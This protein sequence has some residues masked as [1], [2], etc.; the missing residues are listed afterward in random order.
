[1]ARLAV[2][3]PAVSRRSATLIVSG[4]LLA[5][6][7]LVAALLPVPYVVFRPGPLTDVLGDGDDG[8]IIQVDGAEAYATTGS[9]DLTTV[10]VTPAG[11][12]MD[13]L[14]AMRAWV[15]PDRA[16]VPRDIVYPGNPTTEE[17]REVNS[18]VFSSSQELASVA[19][20]RYLGYDVPVAADQV[21][22]RDVLDGA[23]AEGVLEPGDEIL[24][25]D[26][27]PVTSPGDVVDAVSVR[28]PGETVPMQVIRDGEP[29]D[30][31]VPTSESEVDPG[32]AA[33]GVVVGQAWDLPVEVTID[34]PGQ[35]GGSSA[36][37]VFTLG[38]VDTLTPDGLLGG[39]AVAGTG[40][41]SPDGTVGAI[42]GVQQ[43]IA[44]ARDDGAVVFLVPTA[45]CTSALGA[46][47][48][49]MLVIPVDSLDDAVEVLA[50]VNEDDRDALPS[51][52]AVA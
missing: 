51:C 42:S 45:N 15:D 38:I 44:A 10:G 30:L 20:L 47:A 1:M 2:R 26:G 24:V 33:I 22:V 17:A 11:A 14:T 40:E 12:K 21:V 16:V 39:S 19:A 46:D 13:L 52:A 36:G 48:G 49:D 34:V 50:A 35:I 18:A 29:L 43:K 4:V 27:E 32:S 3:W 37:L 6:L 41:I 31:E 8:P 5:G 23:A 28:D 9:L 7:V 25:V